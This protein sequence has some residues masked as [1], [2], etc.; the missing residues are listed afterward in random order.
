MLRNEERLYHIFVSFPIVCDKQF[1]IFKFKRNEAICCLIGFGIGISCCLMYRWIRNSIN[2]FMNLN[3][4]F[5]EPNLIEKTFGKSNHSIVKPQNSLNHEST[6]VKAKNVKT[7][8]PRNKNLISS[9]SDMC[10]RDRNCCSDRNLYDH[11]LND[12][13]YN[14]TK[15]LSKEFCKNMRMRR[16]IKKQIKQ[17]T[18]YFDTQKCFKFD[19]NSKSMNTKINNQNNTSIENSK[20]ISDESLETSLNFFDNQ[21]KRAFVFNKSTSLPTEKINFL[22]NYESESHLENKSNEGSSHQS[23]ILD[24]EDTSDYKFFNSKSE[25]NSVDQTLEDALNQINMLKE[26]MSCL[27]DD[28]DFLYN[29]KP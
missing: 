24:F 13:Y 2:S 8:R 17:R 28:I 22:N 20:T 7:K 19:D 11:P 25:I 3:E 6:V 4:I 29:T 10:I 27:C 23:S 9:S 5:Y 15:F 26:D 18:P 16:P 21:T 14:L 12:I 1:L